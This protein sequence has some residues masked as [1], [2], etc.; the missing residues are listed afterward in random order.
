[1]LSTLFLL[2]TSL[3]GFA[4]A[5]RAAPGAPAIVRVPAGFLVAV[6]LTSGLTYLIASALSGQTDDA[7]QIGMIVSTIAAIGVLAAIGRGLRPGDL[8]STRAELIVAVGST[9]VAWWLMHARLRIDDQGQLGVSTNTWSDTALHMAIARSFSVGAN[10]PT[11]YPFFADAPIR[12]HFGFDFF[13][14]MLQAGGFSPLWSFNLPGIIGF[15]GM[16]CVAFATARLLFSPAEPVRAWRDQGN[17]IG[18][19]AIVL[20]LTNPSLEWLRYLQTTAKGN[21]W[22]ALDPGV[23]F[24]K[25]NYVSAG[26]YSG[27]RIAIYDSLNPW[28]AQTHLIVAVGLVVVLVYAV[29]WLLRDGARPST[30]TMLGLGVV[31]GASFWINGV[32]WL[33]AGVFFFALLGLAALGAVRRDRAALRPWLLT[34]AAFA[35]PALLLAVPQALALTGG[36]SEGG[37]R[38]YFGYIVCTTQAAGCA[39]PE[40]NPLSLHDWGAFVVYWWLN[41]SVAFPLLLVAFLLGTRR[42]KAIIAATTAIFVWGNLF[43]LGLDVGGH[44]HKT[45][46]LWEV[47]SGPFVAYAVVQ[48]WLIGRR[49]LRSDG[50]PRLAIVIAGRTTAVVAGILLILSGLVDH[51]TVKNDTTVTVFGDDTTRQVTDW[52]AENTEPRATFLTDYD[53]PYTTPT[54]A[55]RSVYLGYSPWALTSGY[56]IEPRKQAIS[57][58]YSSADPIAACQLLRQHGIDYA[59][60]GPQERTS[61]RFKLSLS[62]FAIY[63]PKAT[64]GEGDGQYRI[65]RTADIC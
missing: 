39:S 14:G 62:G 51:G 8:R 46:N 37:I 5:T 41:T 12:Y 63:T 24:A 57:A 10:Y 47:L 3:A 44:N 15:A 31:F 45:F 56:D 26:P 64:F 49:R 28:L 42:D 60:V 50:S 17:W 35:I 25:R 58:I 32:V 53:Q 1:M 11:E 6:A 21:V 55:G 48:L 54:M 27:D 7:V 59:V 43:T 34:G 52:I 36:S 33:G 40:M 65:Y 2:A 18:L 9:Y 20:L 23:L 4:L 13:A 38:L 16:L 22:T 30:R 61:Q 19:G 29:L